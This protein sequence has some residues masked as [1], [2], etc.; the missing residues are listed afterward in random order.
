MKSRLAQE[1]DIA[2]I[3]ALQDLNLVTNLDEAQKKD[4]FVTTPFTVEQLREL[5]ALDGL[6]VVEK[7]EKILGYAAAA[8]W[9]YFDGR[10]MFELMISR[11]ERLHFRGKSISREDSF[12][13]GPVCIAKEA[14]GKGAFQALFAEVVRQ[15]KARYAIGTTFINRINARS[16][17]AHTRKL[18]LEPIDEFDFNGNGYWGLA[19]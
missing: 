17:E 8:H 11:F 3:L 15:M 14:R 7:G 6:F 1:Q 5:I 18:G 13:Y 4:G 12:Q 10:P 9:D 16:Y 2:P 19:F